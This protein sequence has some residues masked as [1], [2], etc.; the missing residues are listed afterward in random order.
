MGRVPE[1]FYR[2]SGV[3]PFRRDRGSIEILLITSRR[4]RRWVLPK[5]VV[6]LDLDPVA[7]AAKEAL[8]E[9]GIEGDVDDASVGTYDYEKWG[10]TCSVQVFAMEVHTTYEDWPESY[11][12]RQWL[13]PSEAAVRVDEPELKRIILDFVAHLSADS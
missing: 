3:L 7:S 13:D 1:H 6:E 8:E 2:Q 4:R 9:A 10:G 11:R 5:G 12:G